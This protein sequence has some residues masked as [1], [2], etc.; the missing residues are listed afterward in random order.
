MHPGSLHSKRME[1]RGI[2][3]NKGHHSYQNLW[4]AHVQGNG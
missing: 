4:S 2:K 3:K 1:R